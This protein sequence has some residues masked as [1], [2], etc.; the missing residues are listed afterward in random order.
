MYYAVILLCQ[1]WRNKDVQ[2]IINFGEN[3]QN[4]RYDG[5][6]WHTYT[7]PIMYTHINM[8]VHRFSVEDGDIQFMLYR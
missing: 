5:K 4:W 6:L 7:L 2:S 3:R 8:A 1:E